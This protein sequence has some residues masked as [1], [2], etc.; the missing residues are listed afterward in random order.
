MPSIID[1]IKFEESAPKGVIRLIRGGEFYRAYNH[2]A[3]LF[4]C[5]IT[6]YTVI[7]KYIKTISSDVYYI[8]FPEKSLFNNIGDR[9]L[10]KTD[11]GFDIILSEN[12]IPNEEAYDTWKKTTHTEQ[13]SKSNFHALP[14]A[15]ADAE[16]EVI[17]LLREYPLETKP[18]M[19]SVVFLSQLRAMLNNR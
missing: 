12:E 17:R 11:M 16:R 3:W 6:Q 18:M 1:S 13:A 10:D 2:S 19:D 5:C 8:G 9:K 4:Q 15:G 7:R 14:L